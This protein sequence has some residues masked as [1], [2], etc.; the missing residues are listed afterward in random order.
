MASLY[1]P[2]KSDSG[3]EDS[4]HVGVF[5]FAASGKQLRCLHIKKGSLLKGARAEGV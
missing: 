1:E 2:V 4:N 3:S 5:D